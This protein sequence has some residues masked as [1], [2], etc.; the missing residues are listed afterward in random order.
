LDGIRANFF[1]DG[2]RK[3]LKKQITL[4]RAQLPPIPGPCTLY[5]C[6]RLTID[7]VACVISDIPFSWLASDVL[8][9]VPFDRTSETIHP[10]VE[11]IS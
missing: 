7:A 6:F 5:P 9:L 11:G 4:G 1:R 8:R 3:K 2:E 10:V